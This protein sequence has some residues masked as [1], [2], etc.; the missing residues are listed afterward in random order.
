[1]NNAKALNT[2]QEKDVWHVQRRDKILTKVCFIVALS[3]SW[4]VI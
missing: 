2:E 4:I 3:I 1:M